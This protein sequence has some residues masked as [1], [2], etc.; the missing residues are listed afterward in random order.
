MNS[1]N[2][3]DYDL[4]QELIAQSPLA[5]RD[6]SRLMILNKSDG[7]IDHKQF[8]QITDYL[9]KGDVLV[10]NNTKVLPA[11]LFGRKNTGGVVEILLLNETSHYEWNVLLKARLKPKLSDQI[12][13]DHGMLGTVQNDVQNGQ[14]KMVFSHVNGEFE[15]VHLFMQLLEK[16]GRPPLPPYIKREKMKDDRDMKDSERYQTVFAEKIGAIAAPT[17]GLHFTT[18][19]LNKIE[20][21]GVE[22]VFVTL[23]VGLGTFKP[24]K[25]DDYREHNMHS[26]Y[27]EISEHA[28]QSIQKAKEENRRVICV[29]TTSCRVL[30]T[31][32]KD[33][34]IKPGT[35]WTNLFIYPPAKL[36]A[37]D[38]LIT[39]FHQPKTTLLLLVSAFAG[40]ENIQNAY[41]TAIKEEYRFFSYGDS[42]FIR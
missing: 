42:M 39:N 11:R 17:A 30:E 26:E 13:F 10:F 35:G 12:K 28:A 41:A 27:Y 38:A 31:V 21:M 7:S 36:K 16:V 23:H 19:L 32:T 18:E 20:D 6:Q 25:T 3:F 9:K 29:G 5:E 1:L 33:G 24:I 14:C 40:M 37:T 15:S 4:P 2:N 8:F 22:T 34:K